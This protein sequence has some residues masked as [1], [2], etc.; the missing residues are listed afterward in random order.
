MPLGRERYAIVRIYEKNDDTELVEHIITLHNSTL[1]L[2][3]EL[4]SRLG[5]DSQS[6]PTALEL[7]DNS[8]KL[9]PHQTDFVETYRV[10]Y[11]QILF[12]QTGGE[13]SFGLPAEDKPQD[14]DILS[15]RRQTALRSVYLDT[16]RALGQSGGWVNDEVVRLN[17]QLGGEY[18]LLIDTPIPVGAA[19]ELLDRSLQ[20]VVAT[21]NRASKDYLMALADSGSVSD[22]LASAGYY[23]SEARAEG[24]R[25]E[26]ACPSSSSPAQA[27]AAALAQSQNFNKDPSR[28]GTCPKCRK[29]YYVETQVF[30]ARILECN[31]CHAAIRFGGG[32]VSRAELDKL[33]GRSRKKE[34]GFIDSIM[35]SFKKA[36]LE[37]K[38]DQ[39]R[40][41][42]QVDELSN[43]E[44]RRTALLIEEYYEQLEDL[45]T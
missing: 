24:I 27:E 19:G 20:S 11:D 39:Q 33:H 14:D 31:S 8:Y 28:C 44:K 38:I 13:F 42:Y 34:L 26:G 32:A 5:V 23:G 21:F 9:S 1:D 41:Q 36:S 37:A 4:R 3:D 2:F 7:L 30:K 12:E 22:A 25:Y 29:Q 18:E 6:N 45:D 15:I 17:R 16:I 10:S 35:L 40:R 43:F